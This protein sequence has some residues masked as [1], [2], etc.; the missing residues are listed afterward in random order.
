MALRRCGGGRRKD[1]TNETMPRGGRISPSAR[2]QQARAHTNRSAPPSRQF[3]P[4]ALRR[5]AAVGQTFEAFVTFGPLMPAR[6]ACAG[7]AQV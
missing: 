1:S 5:D 6:P 4:P 7:T 3:R 2:M